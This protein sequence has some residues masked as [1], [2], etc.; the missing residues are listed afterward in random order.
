M[1]AIERGVPLTPE[2]V[3]QMP[4]AHP[5]CGTNLMA[6]AGLITIIF[7]HLPSFDPSVILLS[8]IF[9]YFSWRSFGEIL[10]NYFTTKP[11]TKKQLESGIRAGREVLEKYQD[12][13]HVLPSFGARLLRSGLAYSALGMVSVMMILFQLMGWL[14]SWICV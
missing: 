6:L 7:Q 4:R 12:E 5:R 1:W 14:E 9:V 2:I 11:A 13:P 3:A 10:Q 8:L